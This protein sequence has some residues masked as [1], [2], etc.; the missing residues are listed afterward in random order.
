M[1]IKLLGAVLGLALANTAC[2]PESGQTVPPLPTGTAEEIG[3][4]PPQPEPDPQPTTA[5]VAIARRPVTGPIRPEGYQFDG[6]RSTDPDE[7][8]LTYEWTMLDHPEGATIAMDD[9]QSAVPTIYSNAPGEHIIKLTVTDTTG[10]SDSDTVR[11]TLTN[12]APVAVFEPVVTSVIVGQDVTL[13]GSSS[14]DPNGTMVIP[15][16]RVLEKPAASKVKSQFTGA[17]ATVDFDAAG[18]YRLALSV[19]DGFATTEVLLPEITVESAIFLRL[20]EPVRQVNMSV[21]TGILMT[22]NGDEASLVDPERGRQVKFKNRAEAITVGVSPDGKNGAVSLQDLSV[23]YFNL[24][25]ETRIHY[26]PVSENVNQ[27]MMDNAGVSHIHG[28][29]FRTVDLSSR[30]GNTTD[31]GPGGLR[32]NFWYASLHPSRNY[33]YAGTIGRSPR[34]FIRFNIVDGRIDGT[35]WDSRYHG[36]YTF[37]PPIWA[38]M[39][40]LSLLTASG[41]I[42]TSGEVEETDMIYRGQIPFTGTDL[43][44]KAAQSAVDQTWFTILNSAKDEI[45]LFNSDTSASLG[46]FDFSPYPD[47]VNGDWTPIEV[48]TDSRG[49][50]TIILKDNGGSDEFALLRTGLISRSSLAL[51]PV[52]RVQRYQSAAAGTAVTLDASQSFDRDGGPLSHRWTLVSQPALSAL[53]LSGAE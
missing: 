35:G 25:Q 41:E 13:D 52:S 43:I 17:L 48:F 14:S 39:D 49:L 30:T 37:S 22:A 50:I 2:A 53:V 18:A 24:E 20:D 46:T 28:A 38:A 45:S 44:L 33:L 15:T 29:G 40:G 47:I 32:L 12:E 6:S 23:A 34:D 21:D 9:P 5:P 31:R 1:R 36:D 11:M 42:L 19:S 3:P 26:V 16:W 8:D 51:P 27:I 4:A 10:L 7:D